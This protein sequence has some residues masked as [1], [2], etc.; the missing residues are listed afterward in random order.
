MKK[1][2]FDINA[3]RR[4]ANP[5]AIKDLDKFLDALP[6]NVGYNA[7]IAAGIAWIVAGAAVLF[8]STETASVNKLRSDLL[9][10]EALKP[11]VPTIEYIKVR[12]NELDKIS[13]KIEQTFKP[14]TV[15]VKGDGEIT[16]SASDTDYYPQFQAAI[17][18][19][20]SGGKNWKLE[21]KKLCAGRECTGPAI[22]AQLTL[23][24]ARIDLPP[25]ESSIM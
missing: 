3:L 9:A 4:M 1:S 8:A 21:I 18:H 25:L 12:K 5:Q 6:L 24:K 13:D 7:L 17:S 15:L 22:Q 19:L 10:V 23:T 2:G 16:V 11:P 20:Q 14:V